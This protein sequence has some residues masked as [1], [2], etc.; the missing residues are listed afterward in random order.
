MKGVNNSPA[1]DIFI[2]FVIESGAG[3]V[4]FVL[5]LLGD[6]SLLSFT[7]IESNYRGEQRVCSGDRL[8]QCV[9]LQNGRSLMLCSLP[10]ISTSLTYL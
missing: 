6:Y 1:V 2:H 7:V 3:N 4:Y 8:A 5:G 9:L 10:K